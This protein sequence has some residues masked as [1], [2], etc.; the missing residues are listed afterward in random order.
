MTDQLENIQEISELSSEDKAAAWCNWV[1][2]EVNAALDIYLVEAMNGHIN[3]KYH[4][5]V[6]EILETGPVIDDSKADGVTISIAF[7]FEKSLDL[8]KPRIKETVQE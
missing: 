7:E 5:H 4:P 6:V 1:R 8:T 3:I 2:S